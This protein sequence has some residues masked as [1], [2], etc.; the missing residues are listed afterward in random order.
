MSSK[1]ASGSL[2]LHRCS[3]MR[4][5]SCLVKSCSRP[6]AQRLSQSLATMLVLLVVTRSIAVFDEIWG[7]T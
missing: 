7:F 3:R 5:R 2:R 4:P 1:Y 6:R